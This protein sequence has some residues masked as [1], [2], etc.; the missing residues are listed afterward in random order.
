MKKMQSQID[1]DLKRDDGFKCNIQFMI[2]PVLDL[3]KETAHKNAGDL[4]CKVGKI[5]GQRGPCKD[6]LSE[7]ALAD[8]PHG[9]G[10]HEQ[11][12]IEK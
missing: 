3:I 9:Y 11:T 6:Q 7:S 4:N 2:D 5:I 8:H 1:K 12:H 10:T